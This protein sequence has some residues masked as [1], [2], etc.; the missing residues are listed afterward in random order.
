MAHRRGLFFM[1]FLMFYFLFASTA[2]VLVF[3]EA[4]ESPWAMVFFQSVAF[5]LPL[6][7]WLGIFRENVN[8]HLPHIRLGATNIIYIVGLS[9]LLQPAMVAIS[10]IS[11]IFFPNEMG[12]FLLEQM[13]Y[14]LWLLIIGF[15]VTPAICEEVI[16]RGYIQSTFKGKPFVVTAF[17]NGLF[18]GIIH[19][20]AQQFFYAFAMGIIF[21]Y[22][23]HATRSIRASVISHFI[24]NASQISLLWWAVRYEEKNAEQIEAAEELLANMDFGAGE[25]FSSID[26]GDVMVIIQIALAGAILIGATFGAGILMYFFR[27]HNLKRFALKDAQEKFLREKILQE[28]FSDENILNEEN[29]SQENILNEEKISNEENFPQENILN[30]EKISQEKNIPVPVENKKFSAADYILILAI[31]SLYVFL[32]FVTSYL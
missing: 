31:V 15:A 20:S 26:F 1:L 3:G 16:F 10:G 7:V 28:N 12:E 6:A 19:F 21:A 2:L 18:F 29:I 13:H 5:L 11:A 27:R 23:V 32:I 22:F 8:Q 30:E 4:A 14:P 9:F 24:L 17:V 25:I